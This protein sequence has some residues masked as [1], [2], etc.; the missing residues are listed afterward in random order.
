MC[1]SIRF[2]YCKSHLS[3]QNVMIH[4]AKIDYKRVQIQRS[5]KKKTLPGQSPTQDMSKKRPKSKGSVPHGHK[6]FRPWTV[7]L[8]P[9][10]FLAPSSN[11]IIIIIIIIIIQHH[12]H[13][14]HYHHPLGTFEAALASSIRSAV[15]SAAG[16]RGQLRVDLG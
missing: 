11:I 5:L 8:V 9:G 13:H 2:I 10:T 7:P 15:A 14:H 12:H 3:T 6:A 1:R 4:S 16:Q